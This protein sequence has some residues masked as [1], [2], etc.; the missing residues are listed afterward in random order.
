MRQWTWLLVGGFLTTAAFAGQDP[1]QQPPLP[2]AKLKLAPL[3]P[4]PA[5][6]QAGG[7]QV[8]EGKLAGR[9]KAVRPAAPPGAD[10]LPD[11]AVARLGTLRG[12]RGSSGLI[13]HTLLYTADGK[14]LISADTR[15]LHLW[16]AT[17]GREVHQFDSA[18]VPA[19]RRAGAAAA[20]VAIAGVGTI[21]AH[22]VALAP[23]GKT[24]AIYTSTGPRIRVWDM[25][26]GREVN[27]WAPNGTGTLSLAFS[28]DGKFL[29]GLRGLDSAA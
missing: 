10:P 12:G 5:A 16:D 2:K 21:T 8:E 9:G 13:P 23:D 14:Y 25:A 6:G 27:D 4:G 3:L 19:G 7:K 17:T 26:S 1:G 18:P 24:V 22:A 29:V 15:S 11:G 20:A 28:P